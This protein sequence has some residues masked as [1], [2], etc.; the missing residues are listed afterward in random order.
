VVGS[1]A[2]KLV[3]IASK[4]ASFQNIT[5]TADSILT[6]PRDDEKSGEERTPKVRGMA[7]SRSVS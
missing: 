4:L 6:S 5:P 7:G 1:E 2:S 3:A